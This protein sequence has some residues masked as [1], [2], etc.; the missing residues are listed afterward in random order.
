M[1]DEELDVIER[2]LAAG[3]NVSL[4]TSIKLVTKVREQAREI[5]RMRAAGERLARLL[6]TLSNDARMTFSGDDISAIA[7]FVPLTPEDPS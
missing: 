3:W 1:S 6:C 4:E 2:A 5:E 7:C